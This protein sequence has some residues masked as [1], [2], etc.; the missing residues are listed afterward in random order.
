M[1]ARLDGKRVAISA[2]AAGLGLVM[3]RSF[4]AAGAFVTVA[5]IDPVA[6]ANL[7]AGVEGRCLDV[8]DPD[9]IAGWLEPF[10]VV[11]VD[12]LVNNAGI[13]G[14]TAVVEDVEIDEWRRC[15][16]VGL[17]AMF[18]AARCVVPG[19]K[20]S[21]AGAIINIASTAGLMGMPLRSP[22]VVAKHGVIG[23][24]RTLAMELGRDGIRVNAIAPGSLHGDRMERVIAAHASAEGIEAS[25]VREMYSQGV[26]M[27]TFIDPQDVADLTLY[28]SSDAGRS[29]SGQV[30]AVDGN[31]ET[32]YPRR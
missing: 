10:S 15:L 18:Y 22:Y 2:G 13:A 8:A 1:K 4:L 9:A 25:A 11:G 12:V 19:M 23:F 32:L 24:T 21:G 28:L 26:S 14:P 30:I 29:I 27:A 20:R 16:D 6:V 31:T 7:P 17:N 3:V 5:D